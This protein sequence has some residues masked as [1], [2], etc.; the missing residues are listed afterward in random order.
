M[1]L[2]LKLPND[3]ILNVPGI[4]VRTWIELN[5]T[6]ISIPPDDRPRPPEPGDDDGDD[7]DD[8][9]PSTQRYVTL[10]RIARRNSI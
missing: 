1:Y 7:D 5:G 6:A 2:K 4:R 3:N 9:T 8:D 10:Q